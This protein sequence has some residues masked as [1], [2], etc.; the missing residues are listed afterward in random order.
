[1]SKKEVAAIVIL[2]RPD[3]NSLKEVIRNISLQCDEVVAI[4]NSEGNY[5]TRFMDE[6]ET[7]SNVM[8]RSLNSNYGIAHAQ[9]VGVEILKEKGYKYV[10]FFDQDSTPLPGMLE[11]LINDFEYLKSYNF[12]VATIGPMPINSQTGQVYEPRLF[13]HKILNLG[14]HSFYKTKQIISSGSLMLLDI[15]DKIGAFDEILF[16]DGVDHEW[17]W[18]AKKF[19]F[20]TFLSTRSRLIHNLGEGDKKFFGFEIAITSTFRLYYQYRNYI[21][22]LF[23][24]YVPFYWKFNNL[25]KYFIK[26]FYY[27]LIHRD[28]NL[29]KRIFKGLSDGFRIA[30]NK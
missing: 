14:E 13:K 1:M 16:I 25:I 5:T 23:R 26:M 24:G 20:D 22:L 6:F 21:I 18:R 12:N 15:F 29:L 28:F 10:V 7:L 9:N 3:W 19:G 4:D 30:S 11:T 17:C 8:Y 27:P 2:Y